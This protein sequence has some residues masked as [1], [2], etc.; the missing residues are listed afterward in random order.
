MLADEGGGMVGGTS[1]VIVRHCGNGDHCGHPRGH[2]ARVLARG[3]ELCV[4]FDQ[5][6]DID[7]AGRR[8]MAGYQGAGLN[9]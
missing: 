8:E 4:V 1:R 7:F 9:L 3:S 2:F 5:P 6:R